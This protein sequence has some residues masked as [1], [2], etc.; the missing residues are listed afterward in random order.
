MKNLQLIIA[1][2]VVALACDRTPDSETVSGIDTVANTVM[3]TK[4][5]YDAANIRLGSIE[6]KVMRTTLELNGVLDVPPQNLVTVSAPMGG[7]VKSTPLL[8][9]KKVKKGEVLVTLENQDYIQLQ[10]DYL[11]ARSRIAVL[12]AEYKRQQ[13]LARENVNSKKALQ[14]ANA[15]YESTVATI[16][17]LEAR[18]AMLNI[19]PSTIVRTGIKS[20]INLYSPIDGFVTDVNVNIGQFVNA[21]DA[22]FRI[23]NPDH[24]HA[25]LQV[26]ENDIFKIKVGQKVQMRLASGGVPRTA[27]VYLIG[28]EVSPDRSIRVHC[29]FDE[30]AA[31]LIPGMFVTAVVERDSEEADAVQDGAVVSYEGQYFVFTAPDDLQF[32]AIPVTLGNSD[33]EMTAIHLPDGF[34]SASPIVVNGA[35]QLLGLLKNEQE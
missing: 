33:G 25:E 20:T 29:H 28:K 12:E 6:R 5:Q 7:F 22:M 30:E 35:F 34:D 24:L 4:A 15:E 2:A 31:D 23:V 32:R 1:L 13:E 10:Q 26:F 27:T 18:L 21:T 9:G 16:A 8:Q 11:Q 19:K 14:Q 3:L 17:G